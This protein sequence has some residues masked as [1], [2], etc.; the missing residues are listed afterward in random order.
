MTVEEQRWINRQCVRCGRQFREGDDPERG[1]VRDDEG[2]ITPVWSQS[3]PYGPWL[4]PDC[5]TPAE[6][7]AE[8]AE[9]RANVRSVTERSFGRELDLYDKLELMRFKAKAEFL[10]EKAGERQAEA[11]ELNRQLDVQ[12]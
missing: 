8:I 11:D 9:F 4:C 6:N 3:P 2:W 10:E 1:I 5:Q 7:A 12:D